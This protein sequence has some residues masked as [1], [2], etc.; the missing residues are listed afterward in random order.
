MHSVAIALGLVG[1]LILAGSP[2][3]DSVGHVGSVTKR[4]AHGMRVGGRWYRSTSVFNTPISE[5]PKLAR[6]NA[7]LIAAFADPT[8]VPQPLGYS[9]GWVPTVWTADRST[10]LVRVRVDYPNCGSRSVRVPIPARAV[11]DPSAEGRMAIM[12]RDTGDEWDF[13]KARQPGSSQAPCGSQMWSASLVRKTTWTGSGST[14][15]AARASDTNEGAGLTRPR[16]TRKP[17]GSTWDHALVFSYKRTLAGKYS[18]PA[19][20]ADGT[21]SDP[22]TCVPMGARFQLDP[23]LNCKRWPGLIQWQRQVCRTLQKYGMI[24]VDTNEGS[25]T[26]LSQ[27]RLSLGSYRYPWDGQRINWGAMPSELLSHFRVLA[28]SGRPSP[29]AA[30]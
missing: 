20:S 21:C 29:K 23:G 24:V 5:H 26:L 15:G 11:P 8:R 16:D 17:R 18:W 2:R 3:A 12:N 4:P 9:T 30:H 6:Y 19:L 22:T 28:F 1:L 10:P 27:H 13:Y 7:T 25:P 14:P